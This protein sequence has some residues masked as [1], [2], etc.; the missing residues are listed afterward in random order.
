[1]RRSLFG[2]L[3][4]SDRRVVFETVQCCK[5]GYN[6]QHHEGA[7]HLYFLF[8]GLWTCIF[9][10]DFTFPHHLCRDGDW[11]ESEKMISD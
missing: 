4:E 7:H 5:T 6:N 1:M 3:L 10:G 11:G 8:S 2:I 9:A